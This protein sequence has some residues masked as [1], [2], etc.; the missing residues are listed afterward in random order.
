MENHKRSKKLIRSDL[1]GKII[2]GHS[3]ILTEE[4]IDYVKKKGYTVTVTPLNQLIEEA[5]RLRKP[6]EQVGVL[7]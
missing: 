3:V 2:N 7:N 1:S 5:R 4:A 6:L